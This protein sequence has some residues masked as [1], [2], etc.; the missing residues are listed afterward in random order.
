VL[1]VGGA[2]LDAY[3]LAKGGALALA[4]SVGA[5]GEAVLGGVAPPRLH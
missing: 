4:E 3:E 1:S 5:A 2:V